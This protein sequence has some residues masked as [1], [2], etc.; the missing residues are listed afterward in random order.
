MVI[1]FLRWDVS[2]CAGAAARRTGAPGAGGPPAKHGPFMVSAAP[3]RLI[4]DFHLRSFF[5]LALRARA[6]RWLELI[7]EEAP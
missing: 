1:A 2:T 3:L 6:T 5:T 7:L 4:S